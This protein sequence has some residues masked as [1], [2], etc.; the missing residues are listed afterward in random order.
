MNNSYKKFGQD[1]FLIF[2]F[3][4]FVSFLKSKEFNI[5]LIILALLF[6]LAKIINPNYLK[7][8][9]IFWMSLSKILGTISTS[10]ILIILYYVIITPIAVILKIFGKNVLGLKSEDSYWI[11]NIETEHDW[12][13]QY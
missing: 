2:S 4:F 1:M 9:Y 5:Y 6:L 7:Y 8:P 13:K 11:K 12:E 3:I 10:L